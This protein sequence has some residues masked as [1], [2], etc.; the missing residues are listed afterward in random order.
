MGVFLDAA[1][2]LAGIALL[3]YSADLFVDGAARLA[4]KCGLS[5]FFVGMV[6]IGFGTSMPELVVSL[7]SS[8][9]GNG[10]IALGNAYGS[11]ICNI[12]LILGLTAVLSPIA[13]EGRILKRDAPMLLAATLLGGGLLVDGTVSLLDGLAMAAVFSAMM[14]CTYLCD[15]NAASSQSQTEER[16]SKAKLLVRL[17]LGLALLAGSSKLLVGCAASLARAMGVPEL[18]IGL[19]VIA[20]GTSLPELAS[21]IA[22]IRKKEDSIAVGNIVGSNLFNTLFV[23]GAAAMARPI[24]DL[25]AVSAVLKRDLPTALALTIL[26]LFFALPQKRG[27][28]AFVGRGKGLVLLLAYGAYLVWLAG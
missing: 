25:N 20:V 18:V 11:N 22:A 2:L 13:V 3:S 26:L 14:V 9:S 17:L 19:T 28:A 1:G 27:G 24:G 10:A 6:V 23:V 8:A 12:A 21:S 16:A 15:R 4:R 5:P 7:L